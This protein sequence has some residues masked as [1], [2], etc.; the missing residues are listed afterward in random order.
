MSCSKSWGPKERQWSSITSCSVLNFRQEQR[1]WRKERKKRWEDVG[2]EDTEEEEEKD[3]EREREIRQEQRVET[4]RQRTH[5]VILF[6]SS[7]HHR[8]FFVFLVFSAPSHPESFAADAPFADCIICKH[9]FFSPCYTRLADGEFCHQTPSTPWL[10]PSG[11]L[12]FKTPALR[13]ICV[14]RTKQR[15]WHSGA[16]SRRSWGKT[17]AGAWSNI[18]FLERSERDSAAAAVV[19]V[20]LRQTNRETALTRSRSSDSVLLLERECKVSE[21]GAERDSHSHLDSRPRFQPVMW[22]F[23]AAGAWEVRRL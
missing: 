14:H 9:A 21:T 20:T 16:E 6:I 17:D 12:Q 8:H 5:V 1:K 18:L 10:L 19:V 4:A 22:N 7:S 2:G 15:Q 11:R 13:Q 23:P 3:R